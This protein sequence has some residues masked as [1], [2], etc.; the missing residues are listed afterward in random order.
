MVKDLRTVL[1]NIK[2]FDQLVAFL[3]DEMGWPIAS[4]DFEEMTFDYTPEELGI[5]EKTAA[6]IESIK[7]LRP[8]STNQPWGIFFVKFEPKRLPVVALRRI[9]SQVAL[10]K[11]ASANRDERTAWSANDLLFVSNYGEGDKRTITFA[12]FSQEQSENLPVLKVLGW[13]DG[14]TALHL[15]DVAN[16]LKTKLSWPKDGTDIQDW[17]KQWQSAFTVRH[18]EVIATSKDLSIALAKLA[19]TIRNRIHDALEIETEK[20]PLNTLLHA[21]QATLLHDLD[22]TGFADMYAQTVTYGLL[23][24]R[25]TNPKRGTVD[26]LR[27]HTLLT[28]PFL[29]ELK[30][31]FLRLGK[32]KPNRGGPGVDF[33]ELGLS[34]VVG[35]LD[36]ANME[37][38]VRDF[39]DKNPQ[40]DPVIHFYESFLQEYNA[41]ERV[42]RGIFY[43]PRPVVRYIVRSVDEILRSDFSLKDGLADTT[44]WRDKSLQNPALR[45][46]KGSSPDQNFV[47][48]LDPATGTGTFLVETIDLIHRMLK[49]KWRTEGIDDDRIE[50]LWNEYVSKN[51]L[52]RMHGYELLMAPYAIAHLKM[53]L[54]L[55]Q[56]GYSFESEQRLGVYLTNTLEEGVLKEERIFAKWI[57]DEAN[58]AARIKNDSPISVIIGNPPYS[59][60]SANRGLWIHKL[61]DDYK[62]MDGQEVKEQQIK[63]LQDDYVKFI[64]F[65]QWQIEKTGCG[66]LAFITNHAYLD[67]PTYRGMRRS[68]MKSFDD[69]YVLNLHGATKE[70]KILPK[71]IDKDENVFDIK[72]GVAISIFVRRK[73]STEKSEE[74]GRAARVHYSDLWGSRETKYST[75]LRETIE[76]TNWKTI[77]PKPPFYFFIPI[78]EQFLSEYEKG[79][80]VTDIF[81]L[82][83]VGFVT[84]RDRFAIDFSQEE[85]ESRI[86]RFRDLRIPDSR[87]KQDYSLKDTTSWNLSEARAKVAHDS[88]WRDKFEICL[89]RPFDLR[90]IYF[91]EYLLERPQ[92]RVQGQLQRPNIALVTSRLTKGEDFAHVFVTN[93]VTEVICLSPTTS[94]NAFVFPLN[95][96]NLNY[97][98]IPSRPNLSDEFVR[99]V[100]DSL[101][102][103]YVGGRKTDL[104]KLE[105]GSEDLLSYV[106]A[107]LHSSEYRSRYGEFLRTDFPRIPVPSDRAAF[108]E[109]VRLG[110]ELIDL[111]L[112]ES[113]IS[114]V[115]LASSLS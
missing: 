71:N 93:H 66:I 112:L 72:Q 48:I 55:S 40:E 99:L 101:G 42:Q 56:L 115:K 63:W 41:K 82:N 9:L 75:L 15:D 27:R 14:N 1:A 43:T 52:T 54:Q 38:I 64:R 57:S 25:I 7:R 79:W 49:S 26:D 58:A 12:H 59:G 84:A 92:I 5:D 17:R 35:L 77:E 67:N 95:V 16:E 50:M 91:S 109:L 39:G 51:L 103:N 113:K 61:V 104:S 102:M 6:K 34:E 8:L 24:A 90:H 21:F 33:D 20:G 74:N 4:S 107:I 62:K 108:C 94:N 23:F 19:Q 46:P 88:K 31:T 10:K 36:R 68:L 13:N 96:Y 89:Y 111:H 18:G 78:N 76:Q 45:I 73:E 80:K 44:N 37:A 87:I 28:N 65:G 70:S 85:L 60:Q 53:G 86:K 114:P 69:I 3:R 2:R 98:D 11:R 30:E 83:G 100:S 47:Q 106:Y 22:E 110:R 105:F 97:R 32:S 81:P 29:N